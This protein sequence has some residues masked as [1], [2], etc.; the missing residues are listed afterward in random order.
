MSTKAE[1]LQWH[2]NKVL[3]L[4][5]QGRSQPQIAEILQLDMGTVNRGLRCEKQEV[6]IIKLITKL[7]SNQPR[8]LHQLQLLLQFIVCI[9]IGR[10]GDHL[11]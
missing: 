5:S 4:S 2:R 11:H 8:P 10:I 7:L 6:S 3:E 1:R 9:Y